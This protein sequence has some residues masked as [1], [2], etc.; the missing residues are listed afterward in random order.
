MDAPLATQP[1]PKCGQRAVSLLAAGGERVWLDP[2]S[3]I[4][5]RERDGEGGYVW[6]RLE[7]PQDFLA[8]HYCEQKVPKTS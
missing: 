7:R 5:A 1:C 3:T 2:R 6:A 4:Y 8:R